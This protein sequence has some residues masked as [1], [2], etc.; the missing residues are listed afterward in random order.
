MT[1]LQEQQVIII[2][3]HSW[4]SWNRWLL[5]NCGSRCPMTSVIYVLLKVSSGC[6]EGKCKLVKEP[7]RSGVTGPWQCI[8]QVSWFHTIGEFFAVSVESDRS[9]HLFD[10][11]FGSFLEGPLNACKSRLLWNNTQDLTWKWISF[12]PSIYMPMKDWKCVTLLW[13]FW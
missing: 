12:F 4:N 13:L 7:M 9:V 6:M 10:V 2:C 3:V 8:L 11:S 5:G 1:C